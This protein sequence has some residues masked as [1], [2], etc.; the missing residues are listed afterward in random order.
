MPPTHLR[1]CEISPETGCG[2]AVGTALRAVRGERSE[3]VGAG[4]RSRTARSAIPTRLRRLISESLSLHYHIIFATE[5]HRPMI[6]PEWRERLHAYLGGILREMGA[7]PE[8][9]GGVADHVHLLAG[10][11]RRMA[12]RMSCAT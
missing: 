9:V 11:R 8:A 7:V 10:C 3:A 12:W 2:A 4:S 6:V 1:D 5:D